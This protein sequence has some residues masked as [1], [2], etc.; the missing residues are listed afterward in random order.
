[1]RTVGAAERAHD[2]ATDNMI[3]LLRRLWIGDV[4]E[5]RTAHFDFGP[6]AR[7]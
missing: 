1:M 7:R 6:V 2:G 3:P 5:E 4:I